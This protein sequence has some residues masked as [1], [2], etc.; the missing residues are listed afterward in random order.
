MFNLLK[1]LRIIDLTTVV[2]GPYATQILGDLGA[3]VIKIESF[4]GDVLRAARPGRRDDLGVHFL[5]FNRNKRSVVLDLKK[6]SGQK[7]LHSLVAGA[8]VFVHNMR[9]RSAAQLGASHET[10]AALNP[11]LVYCY[12]PG[13]GDQGPDRDAPAYD[14]IIQARSGLAS[15]NTDSTGAPQFVP[16]IVCDKVTG[17]HLALAIA[18]GVIQRQRTGHGVCIEAPMLESMVS[19]LLS[20]HLAGHTLIPAEGK[21]AY[22]RMMSKNRRPHKTKDGYLAILPYS[23][24]HWVRFFQICKLEDW[25]TDDKVVDPVSRSE[26][27]DELYGK[28]AELALTRTTAEWKDVLAEQDIP[29]SHVSSLEDL[30]TDAHLQAV[31]M[32]HRI[33]DDRIGEICELRSP[34]Q[35]DGQLGHEQHPNTVAPGIGEHT[36]EVLLELGYSDEAIAALRQDGVV[37]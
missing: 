26:H 5:N 10:L 27:I 28:L 16:T 6:E 25:A 7:V 8:D 21:L 35:V 19:F 24:K 32:F 2:L 36:R 14:D 1:G 17:L 4:E 34:Y 13:F 23:T 37:A 29:C 11:A 15:L 33:A 31:R 20:E 18:S 22:A 12:S 30:L 3:D 9:S